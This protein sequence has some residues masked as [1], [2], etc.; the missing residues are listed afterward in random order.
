MKL[1]GRGDRLLNNT[2]VENLCDAILLAIRAPTIEGETF[3]IR[4]ERLVTRE[5][6]INTIADY[7]GEPHPGHVPEWLA[8]LL[9][10]PM[11]TLARIT[12]QGTPPPLTQARMKF[13]TQNLDFSITKAKRILGYRP[14]VDFQ[15]GII[16]ALEPAS[17]KNAAQPQQLTEAV[18][19]NV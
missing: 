1:I 14:R 7:L 2:S 11:E 5:E 10:R 17:N 18:P 15:E 8:R 3:N 16:S 6:F 13:L 12:G 4:D 9:V 19:V